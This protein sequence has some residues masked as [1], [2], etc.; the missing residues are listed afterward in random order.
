MSESRRLAGLE[1]LRKVGIPVPAWQIVHRENDVDR[2]IFS[3]AQEGW[4]IRTCRTDKEREVGGFYLNYATEDQAR[5][6]LYDRI[7]AYAPSEFYLVYPSWRFWFS[8]NVVLEEQT[9]IIEGA[10]GSQKGIS[11]GKEAPEFALTVP[12]GLRSQTQVYMNELD[13][14]VRLWIW[15]I[16]RYCRRLPVDRFYVEVAVTRDKKIIFYELFTDKL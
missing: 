3:E 7:T 1:L 10:F 8:C 9:H 16:L 12:L 4:S 2:L 11:S 6:V 15:K 13:E 5:K 14:E